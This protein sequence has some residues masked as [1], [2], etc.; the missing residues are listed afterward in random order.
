M[1]GMM[2]NSWQ[3]FAKTEDGFSPVTQASLDGYEEESTVSAPSALPAHVQ[4]FLALKS[5]S[6]Y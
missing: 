2:S 3:W 5:A 6:E 4:E 1:E